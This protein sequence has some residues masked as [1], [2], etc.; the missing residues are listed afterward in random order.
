MTVKNSICRIIIFFSLAVSIFISS[1]MAVNNI[2]YQ[3]RLSDNTGNAVSDGSYDIQFK[4]YADSVTGSA[5]WQETAQITTS[6]GYFNHILGESTPFGSTLFLAN[7]K[8]Y[9]EVIF[10][11]EAVA[12]RMFLTGVPYAVVAGNL[13]VKDNAGKKAVET[14]ADE[15]RLT[16]YDSAGVARIDLRGAGNDNAV[17]LPDSAINSDEILNEAGVVYNS[18]ID[19]LDLITGEMS[20]LM[21]VSI[22]IPDDGYI[23]VH[24]KC[25][26]LLSGT[27]GANTAIIQI[28]EN[29]GG[30]TQFPYY[31]IAGLSGYVNSGTNYFPIFVS[32]IYY[33]SKG[34]YTFRMGKGEPLIPHQ[35]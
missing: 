6:N 29:E 22:T 30:G 28:D 21:Q 7:E 26:V 12:P 15:H 27:T 25:Y 14:S 10:D 32:R 34:T 23:L 1:A 33:K 5:L 18:E 9:L 19:L 35:L 4:I 11:G 13:Q 3:G 31:T 2:S 24:G 17:K 20:D 8:L 16:I